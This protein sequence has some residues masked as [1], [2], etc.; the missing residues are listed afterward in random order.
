MKRFIKCPKCNHKSYTVFGVYLKGKSKYRLGV[1]RFGPSRS[2]LQDYGWSV[3]QDKWIEP[4]FSRELK[5]GGIL[6]FYCK[7]CG[8]DYPELMNEEIL[9]YIKKKRI[10]LELQK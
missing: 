6:G 10:L 1:D 2:L 9:D 3:K 8:K 4:T 5:A 7:N